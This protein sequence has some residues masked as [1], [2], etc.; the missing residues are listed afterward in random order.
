MAFSG[1]DYFLDQL[2]LDVA[3]SPGSAS[4]GCPGKNPRLLRRRS[5]KRAVGH[6]GYLGF[7]QGTRRSQ[8]VLH[9]SSKSADFQNRLDGVFGGIG[10][11][12]WLDPE[13]ERLVV[14]FPLPNS[15][16]AKAGIRSGDEIVKIDGEEVANSSS[17]VQSKKSAASLGPSLR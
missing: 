12:P 16:A 14:Q 3:Q 7:A 8:F 9:R 11:E 15:P 1:T 5:P 2:S 17:K 10:I 6:G 4:R 13:K